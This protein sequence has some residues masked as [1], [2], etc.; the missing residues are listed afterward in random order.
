MNSIIDM[1]SKPARALLASFGLCALLAAPSYA[2]NITGRVTG[3]DGT[4]PLTN[5]WVAVWRNN[6]W[7]WMPANSAFTDANGEYDVGGL[8]AGTYRMSFRDFIFDHASEYYDKAYSLHEATDIPVAEGA[9]VSGINTSLAAASHIKGRVTGPDGT[10]PLTNVCVTAYR[11]SEGD[12]WD[13]WSSACTDANGDY[14][15][16]R[17]AAGA[18]R[19][20][21]SEISSGHLGEYYNNAQ[22][23][24]EAEDIQVAEGVTVSNINASLAVPSRITGRV[25]GLDGTTPL[26]RVWV[27]V[28]RW[29]NAGSC[30][31]SLKSV[32]TDANG[33]YDIGGLSAGTYRVGYADSFTE[34]Y[35]N[36][37]NS[38]QTVDEATDIIVAE[39][40]TISGINASQAGASRITGRV[41]G[42]DGMTPLAGVWVTAYRWSSI[43]SWFW[44]SF[45]ITDDNGNYDIGRLPPGTYRI[46]FSDDT[47]V[48]ARQYYNNVQSVDE[49]TDITA[50]AGDTITGINAS[51]AVLPTHTSTT[52]VSVPFAWL[53][54]YPSLMAAAGGDYEA[55]ASMAN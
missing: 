2:A 54:G 44:A 47:Y 11:Y 41:T 21:F 28:Y 20:G 48:H 5:V 18:Y 43:G 46:R 50:A 29:N 17:L 40:E 19:I 31:N 14:D 13:W 10:T 39:G 49:A 3:S 30:W 22:S 51:L 25:T 7:G 23:V 34:V 12:G 35:T 55:A 32:Q 1:L 38:A 16:G 8:S 45:S 24:G 4:T 9:T 6:E 37:Y 27:A 15:I 33:D 42:S 36:F 26:D 53:D 52:P